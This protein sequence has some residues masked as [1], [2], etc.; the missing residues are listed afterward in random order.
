MSNAVHIDNLYDHFATS[1]Q[2][3]TVDIKES[4][5]QIN[6]VTN[7]MLWEPV[8]LGER[9]KI[10]CISMHGGYGREMRHGLMQEF[11][12]R[13][14]RSI[15]V[16]PAQ[17]DF[18]SQMK[19]FS[20]A[21]DFARS[22]PGVEKVVLMGQSRGAAIMS[23]Y[24]RVAENGYQTFCGPQYR[25]QFPDVGKLTP[26]DGIM[27]LDANYGIMQMLGTNPAILRE[28]HATHFNPE[29]DCLNPANGYDPKGAHY[30]P[31]F[32]RKFWDAQRRRYN[33]LMDWCQERMYLIDAG[34]GDYFDDEPLYVAEMHGM[35][36]SG[37]KLFCMDT[38][39]FSHTE[40]EHPLVHADGSI[41]RQIVP[42]VRVP[43]CDAHAR[44]M[45]ASAWPMTVKTFLQSDVHLAEGWG[46]DDSK[47]T[48][49][50]FDNCM[51]SSTG[52]LKYIRVPLLAMGM[53]GSFEYITAEWTYNN[54]GCADKTIAFVEGA[55][56]GFRTAKETES[57]PGQYGDGMALTADYASRWLTEKGRFI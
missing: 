11:A 51:T 48:G 47:F 19:A 21:M 43:R 18:P 53:T 8:E 31:A 37:G 10:C 46:Y 32:C 15:W 36:M 26:A 4:Y 22:L 41:T 14:F 44:G 7:A 6:R 24:Q 2:V 39:F 52:N 40:G 30:S 23:A 38:N 33:N 5:H 16:V 42:S 13:G 54:A 27:M 50:D 57:Y 9:S 29:L 49:V 20:L 55:S 25:I 45:L 28:G 17:Y 1:G 12:K 3:N 34:K 56:H 35:L